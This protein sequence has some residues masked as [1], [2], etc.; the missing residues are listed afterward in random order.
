MKDEILAEWNPWWGRKPDFGLLDRELKK[1]VMEWVDRKEIVG[2][3]GVRRSGKTSLLYLVIESLLNYINP[4]NILFIKC[5]DDRVEKKDII[6][7][8]IEAY[9]ELVDASSRVFVFIDEIQECEGWESTLKRLY[10]LEKNM[11]FFISGSNFSML[12]EDITYKLAGRVAYFEL[13]PFSFSETLKSFA[14]KKDKINLLSKRHEIK[15]RFMEYMEFGGFPEVFLE[16]DVKKKTQILQF[17]YD[18]IVYR[19]ITKRRQIRNATKMEKMINF[20]LQNVSNPANFSKVGEFASISTDSVSEYVKYLQ[21]AFFIFSV[22]MFSFSVKKQEIN[23]KKIYCVDTGIRNVKGF[24]FSE[25]LGRLAENMVFVEIKRRNC[26]NPLVSVFYWQNKNSEID[27]VVKEGVKAKELIQVCWNTENEET[28]KREF[29]GLVSGM[30]EFG[31]KEGVILTSD[32]E[33]K[34]TIKGKRIKC[35]PLWKWMMEKTF[36]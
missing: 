13:Y 10:D 14:G 20:F 9:K 33:G 28:F 1:D 3:I 26:T 7:R 6:S 22:P 35:I 24:R 36:Q 17:Y 18:T 34:Y 12:K 27:F 30:K 8:S 21:D 31:L 5:D 15:H 2:I 16:S 23:P 25:D 29:N 4:R 32:K 19:D 11:K